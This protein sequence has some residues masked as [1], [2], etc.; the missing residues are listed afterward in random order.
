MDDKKQ[1]SLAEQAEAMEN[2]EKQAKLTQNKPITRTELLAKKEEHKDVVPGGKPFVIHQNDKPNRRERRMIKKPA[3][4]RNRKNTNGRRVQTA[5]VMVTVDKT[6]YGDV[7]LPTGFNRTIHHTTVEVK[8]NKN[9]HMN[10]VKAYEA[11]NPLPPD[12]KAEEPKTE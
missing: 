10:K 2:F 8:V 9:D 7:K 6:K 4:K 3:S 5:P 12:V 1:L 11:K